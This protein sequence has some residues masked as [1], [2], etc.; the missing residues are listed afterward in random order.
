VSLQDRTSCEDSPQPRVALVH[1][2]SHRQSEMDGFIGT[3]RMQPDIRD[4]AGEE[5]PS[6]DPVAPTSN[7]VPKLTVRFGSIQSLLLEMA[8]GKLLD[9][10]HTAPL[11][12]RVVNA[13]CSD[14]AAHGTRGP[15]RLP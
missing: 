9:P 2:P 12:R 3:V 5:K 13:M 1:S 7:G 11:V 14:P 4:P 10:A 8:C 6:I 15:P